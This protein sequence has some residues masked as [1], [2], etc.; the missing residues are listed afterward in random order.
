M[1]TPFWVRW[2]WGTAGRKRGFSR[3]EVM[4]G[5]L[6]TADEIAARLQVPKSWS[7]GPH[8]KE[9][10]PLFDVAVTAVSTIATW[11]AGSISRSTLI[12]RW[13]QSRGRVEVEHRVS[14]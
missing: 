3:L 8:E 9:A 13:S 6:R 11:I 5:S 7:I 12:A 4:D 2:A 10:C 1:P 14:A